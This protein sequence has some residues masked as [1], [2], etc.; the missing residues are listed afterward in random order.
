VT[1]IAEVFDSLLSRIRWINIGGGYIWD[2]TTDFG[3]LAQVIELLTDRY[4][5][6]VFLEPGAGIVNAAGCLVSSVVD[7][8][9]SD[10]KRV[11][12]LDT[13]VN[14]LPEV[15]EYQFE[16][17]VAEHED[18]AP[19]EYILAGCSCLAGDVFGTYAFD[20]P[21]DIGSR[22]TF[23]NVGAYTLVKAHTFNGI[24]LPSIYMLDER[25]E[26]ALI[27]GSTFDVDVQWGVADYTHADFR[28]AVSNSKNSGTRRVAK[29]L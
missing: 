13:S 17:D 22:I 20:E 23:T 6:E 3:P 12:V 15:F 10:S 1:Q 26:L 2:E 18:G 5:L 8:F 14:H 4:G 24:P 28:G 29:L 25:G 7:V 21:L 9:E 16:P 11:A 19:H 27:G